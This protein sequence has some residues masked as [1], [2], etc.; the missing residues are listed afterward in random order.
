MTVSVLSWDFYPEGSVVLDM[1]DD[2]S[3]R[4]DGCVIEVLSNTRRDARPAP[5]RPQP[6]T[7]HP[8]SVEPFR[9]FKG[10]LLSLSE[11]CDAILNSIVLSNSRRDA[12]T[13]SSR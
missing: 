4:L 9:A 8:V 7:L 2:C 3:G 6:S 5:P 10:T 13:T 11:L 1:W 12:P